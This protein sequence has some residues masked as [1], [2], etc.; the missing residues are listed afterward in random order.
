[1]TRVAVLTPPG[2]GAIA[3]LAVVGPRAWELA[4]THFRPAGKPLPESPEVDRVRFGTLGGD[5]VVLVA[6]A[7]DRVEVHCHG[8]RQLVRVLVGL[9]VADGCVQVGWDGVEPAGEFDTRALDPL[10]RAPTVR[11]AGIL[12]D[13]YHGAFARSTDLARLAALA[14]IGRHLVAPWR[15]VVAGPPNVGKSSLV[16][17]L[18]GFTRTVVSP[19]AG[20]TRDVVTVPLALDGWPVELL[21]TAGLRDADGLEAEGI[22]LARDAAATA[23]LVLWVLDGAADRPELPVD[24]DPLL[25]VNKTDQPAGWDWA[26]VPAVRV[27]AA[28]GAGLA[29]LSAAIMARL[30]PNP[31]HPG[32]GVPFTP[33]LADA[34]ERI[35]ATGG[36]GTPDA[37]RQMLDAITAIR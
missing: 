27:S 15:V 35:A 22:A 29:D 9:F 10:T 31:P 20:T 33:A 2:T 12:L 13:Q 26:G 24:G 25:V 16:N 37:A 1:M 17:A 28:T 3:T 4:R 36:T 11:T 5:E 18:A 21:D 34:V 7:T 8:G 23:D 19:T 14:P 32:E 30:V 6:P